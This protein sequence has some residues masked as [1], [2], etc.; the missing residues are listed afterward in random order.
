M[1]SL[2]RP[3]TFSLVAHDPEAQE[4]GVAVA[5]KFLAVG[6]VVPWARAG[7]GAVA[8]QSYANA[9]FGP[10]GL[11][12]MS[13][14][15][16]AEAALRGM[17]A[18]D[19]GREERQVGIVD[20]QGRAATFTGSECYAWA[21]GRTGQHYAAQGN[22]LAGPEVVDGMARTFESTSGVLADRLLTALAAGQDAGGDSRGQQS[23]ALLI[24]KP[25]GGYAGFNDRYVDLRVDDHPTPIAELRRLLE[26]HKL[27]SFE[28]RPED[29]LTIDHDLAWR[30]QEILRRSG[31]REELHT[32]AYDEATSR[33]FRAL[34]GK[35][36]LEGRWREGAEVD[37]VVIDYLSEKYG[38][39]A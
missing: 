10:L 8:T 13:Q 23:A 22:I 20:G 36:N 37:R 38:L 3:S 39:R 15:Y 30:I 24:V 2:Y 25:G 27:Y 32:G 14:G 26:L 1:R 11:E 34:I 5:S 28:T 35:E 33:A 12:L 19:S 29:V 18:A 17:L 31:H 21:G 9:T 16:E 4:W 7:A 6:S